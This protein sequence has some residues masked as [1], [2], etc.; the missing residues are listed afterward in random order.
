MANEVSKDLKAAPPSTELRPPEA[1]PG[2]EAR[3]SF[4]EHLGELRDRLMYSTYAIVACLIVAF[5]FYNHIFAFIK[6][7]LTPYQAEIEVAGATQGVFLSR[8]DDAGMRQW[9]AALGV[10]LEGADPVAFVTLPDGREVIAANRL[11]ETEVREGLIVTLSGDPPADETERLPDLVQLWSGAELTDVWP[12]GDGEFYVLHRRDFTNK[13]ETELTVT[14]IVKDGEALAEFPK[15]FVALQQDAED[16]VQ[17]TVLSPMEAFMVQI[18]LAGYVGF[19]FALPFVLY[20][21]C[22]FVFPGLR[23]SER[24]LVKVM[25]FGCGLCAVLG[26]ALA[27]QFIFPLILPFLID[28]TPAGVLTQFRMNETVNF[29]IKGLLGFAIAFQMPMVVLVL[30][31][32]DLLQP[33]TLQKY[34]RIAIVGIAVV[35]AILTPPDPGSMMMMAVPLYL[36]YEISII[37]A[38]IVVIRRK[39]AAPSAA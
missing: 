10:Y 28:Y 19:I 15:S 8:L 16:G 37:V 4:T 25:V 32:L 2:D 11:S 35:A 24:K 6:R 1:D 12:V 30:V 21:A 33:E 14:D 38:K 27:Y 13:K 31:W 18:K 7:P 3:M 26:V 29:I 17:W 9:S 5:I 36:L 20:Q 23:P 22:G 34:R 39:R